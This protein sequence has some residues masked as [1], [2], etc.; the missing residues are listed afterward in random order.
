MVRLTLLAALTL[1]TGCAAQV[2]L[3]DRTDGR[4]HAGTTGATMGGSGEIQA[5]VEGAQ[6]A[7]TWLYSSSGGSYS[8]ANFSATGTAT[9]IAP[10]GSATTMANSIGT[11]SM[12]TASAQGRGLINM[13]SSDGQFIRCVFDFNTM[14]NTGL[15]ECVRND[16][17][18][19]DLTIRR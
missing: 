4:Q 3:I 13:R 19:Y 2:S 17:R 9:T 5:T 15:G 14:S 6:Y 12:L 7:G 1:L 8:L 18:V 10:R 16:G 11:A